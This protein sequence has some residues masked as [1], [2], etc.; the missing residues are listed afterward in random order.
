MTTPHSITEPDEAIT[1]H[2]PIGKSVVAA[3]A[4]ATGDAAFQGQQERPDFGRF[5]RASL[6]LL[7]VLTYG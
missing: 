7:V 1:K 2:D 4:Q 3:T 5:E 6:R